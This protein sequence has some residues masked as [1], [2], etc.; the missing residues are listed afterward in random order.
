MRG[1]RESGDDDSGAADR[2]DDGD[3][4]VPGDCG[5]GDDR[6]EQREG[7]EPSR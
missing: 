1:H 6:A 3:E 7:G 4:S 2:R 5:I